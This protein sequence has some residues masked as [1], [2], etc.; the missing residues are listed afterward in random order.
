MTDQTVT[1]GSGAESASEA[2]TFAPPIDI[3]E[4]KDAVIMLLDIP[5]ADPDSVD[6]ALER[7]ELRVTAHSA[8]STPPGYTLMH[9]EYRDGS[10]ERA[11]TLSEQIEGEHVDATF[12]DGVLRLTLPKASQSQARKIEVKAA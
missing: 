3:V 1:T 4:T 6:V 9:A 7:Q 2:P 10:Y 11:F 12:K 8:T 5:G